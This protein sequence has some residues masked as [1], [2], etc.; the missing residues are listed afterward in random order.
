MWRTKL[1]GPQRERDSI[2]VSNWAELLVVVQVLRTPAQLQPAV[3]QQS[4]TTRNFY[5]TGGRLLQTAF[6]N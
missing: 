3:S 4:V 5:G 1:G 2:L 6:S